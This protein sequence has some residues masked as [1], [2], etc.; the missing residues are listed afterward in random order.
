MADERK[1]VSAEDFIEM[2]KQ[3]KIPENLEVQGD[4]NLGNLHISGELLTHGVDLKNTI[5]NGEFCWGESVFGG[6]GL[7][8]QVDCNQAVFRQKVDF[9]KAT[10]KGQFWFGMAIA[11]KNVNCTFAQFEGEFDCVAVEIR[12]D[13]NCGF[14]TFHSDFKCNVAT[15]GVHEDQHLVRPGYHKSFKRNFHLARSTIKGIVFTDD[16]KLAKIFHYAKCDVRISL[17]SLT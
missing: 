8:F 11:E 14:A 1:I 4:V 13:F 10:F 7:T 2:L 5:F 3:N 15:T 12:G 9:Y 17:H 16:L 6:E